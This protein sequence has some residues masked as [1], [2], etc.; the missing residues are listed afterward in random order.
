MSASNKLSA[1]LGAVAAT[2]LVAACVA[3]PLTPAPQSATTAPVSAGGFTSRPSDKTTG[4]GYVCP[5]PQPRLE[6]TSKQ[7]N[8]FVWTE[9]IPQDLIDCFELVYGVT[10]N[11]EE[12]SSNEEMY[13]KISAG[14]ASYDLAQ[15]SNY[16]IQLMARQGYLR[17][18][19][20]AAVAP[21]VQSLNPSY[22][23]PAYDP[24]NKYSLPFQTGTYGIVYNNATV[25]PAPES[26]ADLWKPEYANRMVFLDDMR[27]VVGLTLLTLGY[28]LNTKD[29]AQ[30]A[31]A[32]KKLAELV[33][34]IK[35]FDSDSPKTA[36]LGGDVD[37]GMTW[38]GEAELARRE[39]PAFGYV[40]PKEGTI[41]W[42]DTYVMLKDAPNADAAYA[43][44]NYTYQAD[45]FWLMMRDFP[46]TMPSTTALKF[47][48]VAQPALYDTYINSTITNTP[49][50]VLANAFTIEDVGEAA[51]LYDRIWVNVKGQ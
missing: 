16:M 33:P 22:A 18:L 43:W 12:F 44:L 1:V 3:P 41:V 14:G 34:N 27:S 40:Y 21:I 19:D 23:S 28:D 2:S 46:Y 25:S 51:P 13:A 45:M 6:V 47:A 24:G 10:V 26:W 48:Q 29:P 17:E 42:V 20:Q 5:E 49:A 31:E 9:Y 38:T 35:L 15:P 7:V 30:L 50:E 36:L 8:L 32:E 4:T 39:N 37:L 11:R